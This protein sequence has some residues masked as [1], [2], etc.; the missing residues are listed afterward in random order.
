MFLREFCIICAFKHGYLSHAIVL[1]LPNT[2]DR[3]WKPSTLL[4]LCI[5]YIN[6]HRIPF[7][8]EFSG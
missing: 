6:F 4:V 7:C 8:K 2:R 5:R 1:P 3:D